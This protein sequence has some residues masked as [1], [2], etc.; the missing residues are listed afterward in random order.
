MTYRLASIGQID[1]LKMTDSDF[2]VTADLLAPVAPDPVGADNRVG[3]VLA[4]KYKVRDVVSNSPYGT[5]YA[6][7]NLA[8][9]DLVLVETIKSSIPTGLD[10]FA[11]LAKGFEGLEHPNILKLLAYEEIDAKPF[12]VWEFVDF[13]RLEDLISSGGFLE[14]EF[15]IFDTISQICRGLQ[16]AHEKGIPHGYLHPR[17]ICLADLG[18]EICVKIANFG[19][20]HMLRQLISFETAGIV[21]QPKKENDIYQLSILTYFVVTGESPKPGRTLDEILDPRSADKVGFEALADHRPD[22]RCYDELMQILD[23]TADPDEE[24]RVKSARE[25]EDGL[26]DWHESTKSAVAANSEVVEKVAQDQQAPESA[27]KKRRKITNNMRTTV[28]QMVN[29]KSKQFSQEETAVM[30]LTNIAAA[31]GPRQSPIN[32]VIR[33]S[34]TLGAVLLI[35]GLAVY[36]AFFKPREVK[37]GW[38]SASQK[39]ANIVAPGKRDDGEVSI[40]P[41]EIPAVSHA[42]QVVQ[43]GEKPPLMPMETAKPK[44]KLPPFD[45]NILRDLYRAD[46]VATNNQKK[47]GFRIEYREFN[48]DWISR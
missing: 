18:G 5:M 48:K 19:F 40:E 3:D 20:A 45:S 38:V 32:S 46:Y 9:G 29:L 11:R 2:D 1:S 27:Q 25:F 7:T 6:A 24:F 35:T 10:T 21:L 16:F 8:N 37:E 15:E 23:D 22:L 26:I 30:K 4:G 43:P 33:L 13:V 39:F 44:T 12:F 34:V 28:K 36:A 14:Q 42:P 41:I 17:N 31:K 47:R